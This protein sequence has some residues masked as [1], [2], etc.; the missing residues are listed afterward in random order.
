[1]HPAALRSTG[2]PRVPASARPRTASKPGTPSR[3]A[4]P[5]LGLRQPTTDG[6]WQAL[7]LKIL[8]STS[9][10]TSEMHCNASALKRGL[11]GRA[12]PSSLP[13]DEP[14]I[15]PDGP[16]PV[17][18]G[19]ICGYRRDR[20]RARPGQVRSPS[21]G[22]ADSPDEVPGVP[23][24][25]R[26]GCRHRRRSR[27]PSGS[28]RRSRRAEPS[29]RS[30]LWARSAGDNAARPTGRPTGA[31]TTSRSISFRSSRTF[32]LQGCVKSTSQTSGESSRGARP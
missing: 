3:R 16:A 19:G 31:R 13:G 2:E 24:G 17:A 28:F 5:E 21:S 22:G 8:V 32:P 11:Q 12:D 27:H 29:E 25:T 18:M 14:P 20:R 6:S 30:P 26:A 4:T 23:V 15:G 7:F 1:M 10:H 9:R